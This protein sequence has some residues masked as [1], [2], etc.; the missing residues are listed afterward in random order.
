[1]RVVLSWCGGQ[2]EGEFCFERTWYSYEGYR[3]WSKH[4]QWLTEQFN[5][6][7]HDIFRPRGPVRFLNPKINPILQQRHVDNSF[8]CVASISDNFL[9]SWTST[10]PT[11]SSNSLSIFP[12]KSNQAYFYSQEKQTSRR[13]RMSR[14]RSRIQK[15]GSLLTLDSCGSWLRG[16]NPHT[17]RNV[18]QGHADLNRCTFTLY[19]ASLI[20]YMNWDENWSAHSA[21]ERFKERHLKLIEGTWRMVLFARIWKERFHSLFS[22]YT[23]WRK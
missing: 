3:I 6:F 23:S 21:K 8:A 1:M 9:M 13:P 5:G 4:V 11:A 22:R 16:S 14:Y 19:H 17:P 15:R 7:L 20:K 18:I 12:S 2:G 10:S